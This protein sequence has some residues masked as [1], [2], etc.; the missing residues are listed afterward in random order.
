M[1][2]HYVRGGHQLSKQSKVKRT[3]Q[4]AI[5]IL[6]AAMLGFVVSPLAHDLWSFGADTFLPKLSRQ[7][8]LSLVATLSILCLVLGVLLYRSY[9]RI[10]LLRRFEPSP[11][12]IGAYCRIKDARP[13]EIFC[14]PCLHQGVVVPLVTSGS[15][16]TECGVC[17]IK[18]LKAKAGAA[19]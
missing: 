13:N 12:W 2:S 15:Y 14:G 17:H 19:L 4:E 1:S 10:L 3:A 18:F 8:Q 7:G 11:N 9:S 6:I 5:A 16:N